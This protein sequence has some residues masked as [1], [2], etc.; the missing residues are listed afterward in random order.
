MKSRKRLNIKDL[1]ENQ[2]VNKKIVIFFKFQV[3]I[4]GLTTLDLLM[5]IL[6]RILI[7]TSYG[8]KTSADYLKP[9][10]SKKYK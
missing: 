8:L 2:L 7:L 1:F 3:I 6:F 4:E 10:F 5:I 9:K